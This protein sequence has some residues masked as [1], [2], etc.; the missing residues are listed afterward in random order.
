MEALIEWLP[1][2]VPDSDETGIVHGDY[3]IGN[4]ILHPTEPKIAAVLDWELST[5]GPPARRSRLLLPELPRRGGHPA[6][7]SSAWILQRWESRRRRIRGALLRAGRARR[8]RPLGVL[9]V[10]VMFRSAAIVQG[11]Y[12]RGLDGNAS[13]EHA[14]MFG[15]LVRKRAD[16]AWNL[17]RESGGQQ[18]EPANPRHRNRDPDCGLCNLSARAAPDH[19]RGRRRDGQDGRRGLRAVEERGE[20]DE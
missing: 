9:H 14:H 17:A 1:A 6:A 4:C 3:R 7:R 12:K 10:F 15:A 18:D 19:A 2:N 20:G 13:S 16:D 5:L 11:V 8:H